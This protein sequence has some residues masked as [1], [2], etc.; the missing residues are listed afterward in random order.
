MG[1]LACFGVN[2][3]ASFHRKMNSLVAQHDEI[4]SWKESSVIARG[5][6]AEED[7]VE[8]EVAEPDKPFSFGWW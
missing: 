5:L 1:S 2:S 3:R 7:Q 4:R 6:P 8:E